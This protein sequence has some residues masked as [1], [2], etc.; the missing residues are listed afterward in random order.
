MI[1]YQR[2]SES[3]VGWR[4]MTHSPDQEAGGRIAGTIPSPS[5]RLR[6]RAGSRRSPRSACVK[7]EG[8]GGGEYIVCY[9]RGE[10][11][12]EEEEEEEK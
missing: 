9:T 6:I 11:E 12:E 4:V 1:P 7:E 3:G 10:E 8:R 5:R 2:A